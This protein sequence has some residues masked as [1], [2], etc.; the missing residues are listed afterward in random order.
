MPEIN[1]LVTKYG[2]APANSKDDLWNK[3]NF[4][5]RRFRERFMKDLCDIH[6]DKD[7]LAWRFSLDEA[8]PSEKELMS[9]MENTTILPD[10][11]NK[12]NA[13]GCSGANGSSCM[14]CSGTDGKSCMACQDSNYG[15]TGAEVVT[16]IK[17]NMPVVVIASLA[18]V[19]GV[20]AL[21]K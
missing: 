3:T 13:C 16:K 2:I 17:D 7:L 14:S 10:N 9:I 6:P 19:I 11:E 1:G 18:L 12:S 15:I 4:C 21:T 5:L 20:I 8:R